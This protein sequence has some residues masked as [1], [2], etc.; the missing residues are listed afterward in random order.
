MR[1][2]LACATLIALAACNP[3]S[4]NAGVSPSPP[5]ASSRANPGHLPPITVKGHGS[6]K[7]PVRFIETRNNHEQFEIVTTSFESHGAPGSAV[8]TYNDVKITFMNKSGSRLYA[9]APKAKLDQRSN[10]V[11]LSGGVHARN[12]AGMTLQCETLVYDRTTEMI[13]GDG[14]VRMTSRNGFNGTGQHFDS[15]ISLTHTRM[16]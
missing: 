1:R 7:Q 4:P 12:D 14:N 11:V 15:D 16:T 13:H 5:P 9:T 2:A 10:V 8:L 6:T 3:R